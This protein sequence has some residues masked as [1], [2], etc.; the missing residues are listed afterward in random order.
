MCVADGHLLP[1][2]VLRRLS[3]VEPL[4]R[5]A[6]KIRFGGCSLLCRTYEIGQW[7]EQTFKADGMTAAEEEVYDGLIERVKG[8]VEAERPAAFD[9][10]L[11]R[12][13]R[14]FGLDGTQRLNVQFPHPRWWDYGGDDSSWEDSDE[15]TCGL[16]Y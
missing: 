15:G 2:D 10:L 3:E 7:M 5:F 1:D 16:G 13:L 6:D 11:S 12:L 9:R 14:S 4:V 8:E